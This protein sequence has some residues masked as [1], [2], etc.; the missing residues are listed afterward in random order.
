[1]HPLT[2]TKMQADLSATQFHKAFLGLIPSLS[3]T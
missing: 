2:T 3:R 1:M